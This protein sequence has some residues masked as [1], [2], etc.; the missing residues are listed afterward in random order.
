MIPFHRESLESHTLS[1]KWDTLPASF[2]KGASFPFS[3][4]DRQDRKG[5]MKV[6]R[7]G[8]GSGYGLEIMGFGICAVRLQVQKKLHRFD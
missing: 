3:W 7:T 2:S 5:A 4:V 1:L 8:A 6:D